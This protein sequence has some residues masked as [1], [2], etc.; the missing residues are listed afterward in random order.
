[1]LRLG[2]I[3]ATS[4][5]APALRGGAIS[6]ALLALPWLASC[7][8]T[9]VRVP[10]L[11]DG[12]GA[13]VELCDGLDDD[14]DRKVDEDFRDALG[15]YLHDE[16]CGACGRACETP[17]ANA[18]EV[19]CMLR[20]GVPICAA[21]ACASGFGRAH[22]VD[23]APLDD[24]LCLPCI[25][26]AA[27]GKLAGAR[28][29][30]IDG[31]RRCSRECGDGCPEGYV[32]SGGESCLPAA[33]SCRCE[34]ST[35]DFAVA[36]VLSEAAGGCP[37]SAR[38]EGG[39][40]TVCRAPAE[41]CDGTDND[42]DQRVDEQ[43]VDALGS[44][45]VDRQH[46]G[47][48][49]VDCTV[50]AELD[51]GCGGDPFAPSCVTRC[52]DL[53]DGIQPGDLLDADRLLENGCECAV[54]SLSD[55]GGAPAGEGQLDANCDGADGG[56][57]SSFYVATSGDDAAPGSPTR[58]LRSIGAAV[59]LAHASLRSGRPRPNV[60]VAS[61]VYTETVRMRDGVQLHGG[62][63]GDFLAQSAEGFEVLVIAPA[64]SSAF[65]GAA[66][67]IDGPIRQRTLVEGLHLRGGDASVPGAPAIG[68]VISGAS[69]SLV[70]RDLRVHAGRPGAGPN[71]LDG[72]AG[73]APG[74]DA[75][76]GQPP[77]AALESSTHLCL[78]G[79]ENRV[80]GGA[81]GSGLC[82]GIDVSGGAGGSPECPVSG[83]TAQSG[84]PGRGVGGLAGEGG[85]GG[86][87]V[88][89]PIQGGASCPS[90]VCCGLADFSVPS[91][92]QQAQPGRSGSDGQAGAPGAGCSDPLGALGLSSFEPSTA[93]AGSSGAPGLGGG[94]GGGGGG[95]RMT[96]FDGQCEFADGLGGGGGGGGAGGCGGAGGEAGRSGG[97]S[98]AIQIHATSLDQLPV[99]QGVE[100]TSAD[101]ARGGDGGA[102]GDGAAGGQGGFGGNLPEA[103]RSTPTLAGPMSG[104]RGGKG[105]DG[106]GGG[107]G[108]GGCGGSSIAVWVT[109]LG[110]VP[111]VGTGLQ[112]GNTFVAGAAGQPGRGGGGW[113]MAQDGAAG[114]SEEVVVR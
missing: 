40:Q 23:C 87:D 58:P 22:G 9:A 71:G 37:G 26:D 18:A 4:G 84:A 77:R 99:L 32:C 72:A 30:E 11:G 45:S 48:C 70:L 53:D 2:R 27:C 61:G 110:S 82:G 29:A 12:G 8:R 21:T 38:C 56:V 89:G 19:G 103:Q 3:T 96:W 35:L 68:L 106:G 76:D 109:G 111:A 57:L 41:L 74:S 1:M 52:P 42:C 20:E 34:D 81:G 91:P 6:I 13:V 113:T 88:L 65:G 33:G 69:G 10:D 46:C 50:D 80:L 49:G 55:T 78:T 36:C 64:D 75:S 25:D 101:G 93:G 102:G 63:R 28:C 43:F 100:A 67:V 39:D 66:M 44:Y 112:V 107:G 47:A 108:G 51:L 86:D 90:G 98:I 59:E 24:H 17:I 94:G 83:G 73:R 105:G 16:H 104:E 97:P 114:L 60:F 31:E 14:G 15:N 5:I 92:F 79:S 95:A 62:Y 54:S 7:G 85:L